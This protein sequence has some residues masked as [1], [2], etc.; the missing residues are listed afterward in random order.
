MLTK[1]SPPISIFEMSEILSTK[2]LELKHP[3]G[4]VLF[5]SEHDDGN[6]YA[7][8]VIQ[9]LSGDRE[10]SFNHKNFVAQNE[11]EVKRQALEWIQQSTGTAAE[12]LETANV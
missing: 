3:T 2:K 6:F 5:V 10:R 12:I 8:L 1:E 7:T 11:E 9:E 4:R